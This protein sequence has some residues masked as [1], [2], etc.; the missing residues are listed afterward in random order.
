LTGILPF[1]VWDK[2]DLAPFYKA[3]MK[4]FPSAHTILWVITTF[5]RR[6]P[7]TAPAGIPE[8][9]SSNTTSVIN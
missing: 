8:S 2:T 1:E 3:D 9:Q 5:D 6:N 4:W 7:S